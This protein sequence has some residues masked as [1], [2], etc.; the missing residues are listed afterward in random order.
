MLVL[1]AL[2]KVVEP[3][4]ALYN[5]SIF[6]SRRPLADI[7]LF[8]VSINAFICRVSAFMLGCLACMAVFRDHHFKVWCRSSPLFRHSYLILFAVGS[9]FLF[10]ACVASLRPSWN[11]ERRVV[12]L[13]SSIDTSPDNHGDYGVGDRMHEYIRVLRAGSRTETKRRCVRVFSSTCASF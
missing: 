1:R 5:F 2:V 13:A 9:N 4:V 8:V 12:T 6:L 10:P 3:A 7:L 11:L